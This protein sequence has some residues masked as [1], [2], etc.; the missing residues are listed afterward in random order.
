[1]FIDD[2]TPPAEAGGVKSSVMGNGA[3]SGQLVHMGGASNRAAAGGNGGGGA[4]GRGSGGFAGGLG[5]GGLIQANTG[6]G[7][8]QDPYY[9]C[10]DGATGRTKTN[11]HPLI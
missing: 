4:L 8:R 10:V 2:S 1:M 6:G 7:A 5:T 11:I 9:R 3:G